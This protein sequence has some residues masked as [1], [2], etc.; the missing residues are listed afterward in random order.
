MFVIN[1]SS[2]STHTE[3]GMT[4]W[5]CENINVAVRSATVLLIHLIVIVSILCNNN[6]LK[7]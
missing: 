4:D 6:K 5:A 3:K 7:I 1:I 2:E